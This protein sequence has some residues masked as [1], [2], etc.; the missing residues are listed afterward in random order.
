M[1]RRPCTRKR[2]VP[3]TNPLTNSVKMQGNGQ[4]RVLGGGVIRLDITHVTVTGQSAT[5]T[6]QADVFSQIALRN[7]NG[8]WQ[9]LRPRNTLDLSLTLVRSASGKWLV[10]TFTFTFAPGTGP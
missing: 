1:S 2:A 10:R 6:A 3:R 4:F 9:P 8:A 5:V 7:P